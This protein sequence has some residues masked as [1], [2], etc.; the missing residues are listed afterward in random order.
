[1]FLQNLDDDD[2]AEFLSHAS[3]GSSFESDDAAE[4]SE[5]FVSGKMNSPNICTSQKSE[6]RDKAM[7]ISRSS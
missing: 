7:S 4:H 2:S 3:S 1:M 5:V 6:R